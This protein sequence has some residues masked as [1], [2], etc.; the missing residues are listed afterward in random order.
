MKSVA[1]TL[2]SATGQHFMTIDAGRFGD[3][4]QS[5]YLTRSTATAIINKLI[6]VTY[7]NSWNQ[8]VWENTF[9]KA[10]GGVSDSGYIA[11]VQK[12]IVSHASA[13]IAAGGGSFHSSLIHQHSS[14]SAQKHDVLQVCSVDDIYPVKKPS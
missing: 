1:Q 2:L 3:P 14:Q 11:S 13:V 6:K 12:E 5:S 7:N 8:T 4:K 9:I 10:T